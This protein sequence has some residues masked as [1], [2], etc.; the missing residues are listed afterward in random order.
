MLAVGRRKVALGCRI[1]LGDLGTGN[2]GRGCALRPRFGL[3]ASCRTRLAGL[4]TEEK[5]A[6][7]LFV[8]CYALRGLLRR[9]TSWLFPRRSGRSHGLTIDI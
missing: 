7:I 3:L 8:T 4:V 1:G 6:E 9:I 5:T 2:I